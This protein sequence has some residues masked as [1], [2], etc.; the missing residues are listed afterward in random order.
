GGLGRYV[1]VLSED[2]VIHSP[3]PPES[4][5]KGVKPGSF[6]VPEADLAAIWKRVGPRTRVYV[7][8]ESRGKRE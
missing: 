8:Q 2:A 5:L 1:I 4:P 6:L 7:F 3:P